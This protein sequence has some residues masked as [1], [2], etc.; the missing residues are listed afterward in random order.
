MSIEAINEQL[1][2][3]IGV[4]VALL[5]RRSLAFSFHNDTFEEWFGAPENDASL[6]TIFEELDTEKLEESLA[7]QHR[8]AWPEE[9][10]RH[11]SNCQP[12]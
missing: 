12:Q 9:A 4:G 11:S 7:Q 3:A 10:Q 6:A 8:E 2:R 5:D 1:L